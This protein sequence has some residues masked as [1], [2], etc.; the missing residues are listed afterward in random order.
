MPLLLAHAVLPLL[1]QQVYFD[2]MMNMKKE[3]NLIVKNQTDL[4]T[5]LD[6][7]VKKIDD[8]FDGLS[9]SGTLFDRITMR[10][11]E[12]KYRILKNQIDDLSEKFNDITKFEDKYDGIAK[13]LN[14]VETEIKTINKHIYLIITLY[15][16]QIGLRRVIRIYQ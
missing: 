12:K 6:D 8:I 13:H 5:K 3:E 1:L 14:V 16:F 7:I 4:S 11:K 10:N 9:D 15:L 2:F